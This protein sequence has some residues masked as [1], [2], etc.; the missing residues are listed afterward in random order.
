MLLLIL[1]NMTKINKKIKQINLYKMNSICKHAFY[2]IIIN[3][4]IYRI[5][6]LPV[7]ILKKKKHLITLIFYLFNVPRKH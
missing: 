4:N 7:G 1:N 2:Y 3:D 5:F 6:M